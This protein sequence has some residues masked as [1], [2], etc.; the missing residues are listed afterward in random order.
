LAWLYFGKS[1]NDKRIEFPQDNFSVARVVEVNR[2]NYKVSNGRN[3]IVAELSGKFLFNA[4]ASTDFPTVGD[5]V[6]VQY[7]DDYALA[8]IHHI[9][10]RKTLLKR[11]EAGKTIEFQLIAANIDYALLMQSVDF[12]FN[13]NRLERYLVMINESK[14][15]PIVVLS[16]ID[17]ISAA[18]L[19]AIKDQLK[20]VNHKYPVLPIS[21]VADNGVTTLQNQLEA[22]K[23][24]CLLGSSG[25]GKT[26]LLNNLLGEALFKVNEVSAKE[27]KGRHTSTRRQL[28]RL[29]SGS[30]FI[31]TP[32]MK[33]LGNFAIETGLE[34]T[35]D[36]ITA[37]TRQ[38]RFNN[39]THTH[40]AGCAVLGAVQQGLIDE[41]RYQN[42]L[43]L[44]KEAAFYELSYLDKRKRDKA[45]GKMVK[46]HK[47][48]I[49]EK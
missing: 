29:A 13:L 5:W 9:L 30:I 12:N 17:L 34:E 19:L 35:F 38:C 11:K 22:G 2:N 7:F 42:F 26:T 18:E 36:E 40:E 23:T 39:C 37:Y 48:G 8:I 20:K 15:Q 25:V 33:E 6:V 4:A 47:K 16:K 32:G 43:R 21:N 46:S 45:F 1:P 31:D 10:P 49:R 44:Q 14:I 41:A 3:E 24:Y 28:I 27:N